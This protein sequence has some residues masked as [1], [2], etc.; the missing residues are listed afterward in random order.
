VPRS[1]A[2]RLADIRDA[3][4]GVRSLAAGTSFA[5]FEKSWSDQRAAERGL[6]IISEASRH[7]P[8]DIKSLAPAIPW[9]QIA[10]IGNINRHE[11]Q[12]TSTKMV[13][14]IVHEYLPDLAIAVERLI[15]E[16]GQRESGQP[17]PTGD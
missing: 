14:N 9:Q 12:R 17:S 4:D 7:I 8:A 11:Y 5:R 2:L 16:L 13:W 1:V 3:I 6:E 15:V 10:A